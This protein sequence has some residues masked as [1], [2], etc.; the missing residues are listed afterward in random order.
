MREIQVPAAS[1][2]V[3]NVDDNLGHVGFRGVSLSEAATTAAAAVVRLRSATSTGDII[4]T[5][6][7]AASSS[8]NFSHN[9]AVYVSGD[10]YCQLVSGT[11]EG[12]IYVD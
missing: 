6:K 12:C 1:G 2:V 8:T 3:V 7:L 4:C 10:L 11:V 5:V 9:E